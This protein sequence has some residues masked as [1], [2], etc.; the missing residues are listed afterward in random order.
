MA[1]SPMIEALVRHPAY[2][3]SRLQ[4]SLASSFRTIVEIIEFYDQMDG[5]DEI[6]RLEF[7][8]DWLAEALTQLYGQ[9]E[10]EEWE[11]EAKSSEFSPFA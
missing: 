11:V 4:F 3:L 5:F 2:N 7:V 6:D 9:N 8:R 10:V 1:E